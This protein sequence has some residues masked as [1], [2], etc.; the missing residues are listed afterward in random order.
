MKS[1]ALL[2]STGS[3]G[4]QT[5]QLVDDQR[6]EF[7]V[8]ALSARGSWELLLEQTLA[9]RP[10]FV[11]LE[12]VDAAA[13]LAERLP[14][15]V[16]L[17][18]GPEANLELIAAS[19][20]DLA[21]HGMVGAAGLR[22]SAAV[23][24][25]GRPLALANKESMVI[26]G[27]ELMELSRTRSAPILPVDSEHCAIAQCLGQEPARTVRRIILTASGGPFRDGPES[28]A[29]VTRAEALAHPNWEMGPRITVGSATLLNKALEVIEAHH[30]FGLTA[31]QIEVAVH[32]Q[33]VVHSMVEFVDGSVIAQC[34]PPDMAG[35][36]HWALHHPHRRPAPL[37]GFSFDV[38][39]RLDF[40]APDRDRFPALELGF[41]CVREGGSAGAVLNAADEVA[42]AAFLDGRLPFSGIPAALAAA[43]DAP[44]AAAHGVEAKLSR[45]VAAREQT[46]AWIADR[47][48]GQRA[49]TTS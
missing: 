43:L 48:R 45:D 47:A 40:E 32:R 21:V 13:A 19:D 25:R 22:P 6:G 37:A 9:H 28:L 11:A 36:L 26:A 17:F 18:S 34:G 2:G 14:A 8:D 12:D 27:E 16:Q 46:A 20:F 35:P 23:L 10:R 31:D 5:L 7:R 30:L 39:K 15:D 42:V 3:I 4:T 38:F 29:G 33:S 1:L 24:E 44:R 41:R 49:S